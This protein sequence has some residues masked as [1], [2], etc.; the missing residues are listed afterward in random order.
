MNILGWIRPA[1]VVAVAGVPIV[2][3][4]VYQRHAKASRDT[5]Q[6][7]GGGQPGGEVDAVLAGMRDLSPRTAEVGPPEHSGVRSHPAALL[8]DG[9]DS[10]RGHGERQ[11]AALKQTI[12]QGHGLAPDEVEAYLQGYLAGRQDGDDS[13]S[14][15]LR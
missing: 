6:Q 11:L 10:G 14:R 7:E 1:S 8:E 4:I 3:A 13:H 5:A 2:G 12:P 9:L 15:S